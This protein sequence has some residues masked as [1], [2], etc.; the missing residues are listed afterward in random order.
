[1]T[2]LRRI[3]LFAHAG[4]AYLFPGE[5]RRR[6]TA[7]M[8]LDF[9]DDVQ[10][11]ATAADLTVTVGR[12]YVDI[13]ISLAREWCASESLK[14]LIYAGVAHAGIW[15]IGVA[16]AAWQWPGGPP[17]YPVLLTF[18]V[19]SVPGIALIVWRQR[20]RAQRAGCCSLSVAELD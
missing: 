14:L 12:A 1:M 8:R 6:Y 16:I 17:L 9:A 18:A 3:A 20:C 11:C 19:L 4:L 13:V 2:R 10:A 5:F 7:D 15:L